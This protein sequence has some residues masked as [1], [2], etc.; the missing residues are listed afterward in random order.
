MNKK[1]KLEQLMVLLSDLIPDDEPVATPAAKKKTAKK[2]KPSRKKVAT[3]KKKGATKKKTSKKKPATAEKKAVETH[4]INPEKSSRSKSSK[5]K[6]KKKGKRAKGGRKSKG[7]ACR[8]SP[9]DIDENRPNYFD[10]TLEDMGLDKDERDELNVAAKEDAK[11][12]KK[13]KKFRKKK[14]RS[15]LI[16][17][18]CCICDYEFT[19]PASTVQHVDRYR[20][21]DCCEGE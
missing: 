17:V 10:E 11:A 7:V 2:K 9:M 5:R 6:K 3:K 21:N 14:R 18:D 1:E 4:T 16:D 20:C 12:R 15:T 13:V 19:V 8:V